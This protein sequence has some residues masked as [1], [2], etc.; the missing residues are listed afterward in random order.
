MSQNK[1]SPDAPAAEPEPVKAGNSSAEAEVSA[2]SKEAQF[3]LNLV[4]RV[5]Y[6]FAIIFMLAMAGQGVISTYWQLLGATDRSVRTAELTL[7]SL[8]K[9]SLSEAETL[10]DHWSEVGLS[11]KLT[12]LNGRIIAQSDDVGTAS[13]EQKSHR[14]SGVDLILESTVD[15]AAIWR[16]ALWTNAASIF[17]ILITGGLIINSFLYLRRTMH[18]PSFELLNYAQSAADDGA[19][20][21]KVPVI[22]NPVIERLQ[23]FKATRAQ[24]QAFLD[25]APIGMLFRDPSGRIV[26]MNNYGASFYGKTPK[27]LSHERVSF[28]SAFFPDAERLANP[29]FLDPLTKGVS[30]TVETEFRGPS[31][32][33]MMLLVTSFPVKG[34][35]GDVE[36]VGNFFVD[37]TERRN[38]EAELNVARAQ[39]LGFFDNIPT[40]IYLKRIDHTII[41]VS[42]HLAD[43]YG[44][45]P[46]ELIG[47]HEYQ[48][49]SEAMSAVL[50]QI[51]ADILATGEAFL[52][53]GTHLDFNRRE[54]VSRFPIFNDDGEIT[55]IGG[56][57][58]DIHDRAQAQAE[59]FETRALFEA[60]IQNAPNPMALMNSAGKHVMLNNAAAGYYGHT[61]EE[62]LGEDS[63]HIIS[64][65]PEFK[66]VIAPMMER[67]VS[68]LE[69][70]REDTTFELPSGELRDM[71]FSLFPILGPDDQL[72]FIGN[73]S[74]DLSDERRAQAEL[75]KSTEALHQAE[76]LAALGSMLAGVSHE[77]N[78]PLAAVIGQAAL[79]GEDLE[80]SEY[81]ERISKI[82]RAADRCARIVQSFLAMARQKPPEYKPVNIN[83]QIRAA[84]ELTEYQMRTANVEI[85]LQLTKLLP[86]IEADPDQLH[87]V[88]V[89]L[90][91]NARQ[92]LDECNGQ[93]MIRIKTSIEE[94]MV[95]LSV[96]DN[97]RGI[98]A[99]MRDRIFDPFFTTKDAGSGTGIGLSYSLGIIEAHGGTISFEDAI[100]G[101]TFVVHLPIAA[102]AAKPKKSALAKMAKAKGHALVIDDEEDVA[103]TLADMLERIGITASIAI[104]GA[105]G[106]SQMARGQSYDLILSDIRMPDV[107]GP[108]LHAW[109]AV[110][111]P[112]L[113]GTL[114]FVTGDTMS[115]NAADFLEAVD[116]PVLEKPF[117]PAGLRELVAKIATR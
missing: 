14:I 86:T 26:M 40:T 49:H 98:D 90:L 75:T 50:E 102:E 114:A 71:S 87:Q 65:W 37:V 72:A 93:R 9:T 73:I 25:H 109:I 58:I 69:T 33:S 45:R 22:W 81:S 91:T 77:L 35:S 79:L 95:R 34:E 59:L 38:A 66:T 47:Q 41:Y 105:A 92:A 18:L 30:T 28:F 24:M 42:K 89:N 43:Q 85:D 64:R 67:V 97:G 11:F 57:N 53:E 106:Q 6:I 54:L 39:L 117:T 110:N 51:D 80:G 70:Q 116:C 16:Q 1:V 2:F 12:D 31:G 5:T 55:H 13:G 107:D 15:R 56:I 48:F 63:K 60:F 23:Q 8:P 88:I 10:L 36:L 84:V 99:A 83:E 19:A 112:D 61:P 100:I 3:K 21:P 29:I 103:A 96:S 108:T 32:E 94:G 62:M 115:G 68:K 104:G 17:F 74:H 78:N 7:A 4:R 44:K 101:T 113:I 76:K 27:E 52:G 82:R 46:E 20:P 111:R